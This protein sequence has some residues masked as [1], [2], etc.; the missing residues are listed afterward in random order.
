MTR[1]KSEQTLELLHHGESTSR[2]THSRRSPYA[3]GASAEHSRRSVKEE[4]LILASLHGGLAS[5]TASHNSLPR[6]QVKEPAK[7]AI[8]PPIRH[9]DHHNTMR[10]NSRPQTSMDPPPLPTSTDQVHPFPSSGQ[11]HQ[12]TNPYRPVTKVG[13]R[14]SASNKGFFVLVF[15]CECLALL[16]FTGK[17]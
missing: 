14:C 4:T 16:P 5:S 13:L 6:T 17:G 11:L 7:R 8:P 1:W 10:A 9:R 15:L 2:N 12:T 3:K